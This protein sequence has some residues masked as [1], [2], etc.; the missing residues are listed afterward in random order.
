VK[1]FLSLAIA[2]APF[3]LNAQQA[4]VK[5]TI[6][7]VTGERL[8]FAS[9]VILPDSLI[10]SSDINGSY[11]IRIATGSKTL[12]VSYVGFEPL[13]F[14]KEI[15]H[16]TTINFI[17][18]PKTDQLEEV[19][20]AGDRFSNED[21][22][23]SV[24]SGTNV[25]TQK[26]V[27]QMPA[28]MG[29][30]NLLK[31]IRLLPGS[32]GG[33]EGS[34]DSFVR[35]G[36]ADQNLVLLDG[37]PIYNTGHLFGFLSV[38]NPD[39]LDKV[40]VINGG[41]PAAFGGR[42]SSVLDISS[43]SRIPEKTSIT[44]DIGLIGSRIKLEQPIIKDKASFWIAGRQ[45]Y[46]DEVAKRIFDRK[47]PYSFYDINGKVILHPSKSDQIEMSH[48]GSEDFL[49]FLNDK[50]RDGRGMFT[51]YHSTNMSQTFKWRHKTIYK[52]EKEL[53]M[54]HTYFDYRTQ[55]A[56]NKDYLVSAHSQIEDYGAKFTIEKDSVWKDALV[57]AGVEWI[58][59][60][61]S[62]RVLN[63]E[64]SI[65]DI[66]KSGSTTGKIAQ[67]FSAYVQ[68][69]WSVTKNLKINIGIRGSMAVVSSRKYIFLE[70]RLS[71]RYA[72]GKDEALKFNYSRMVQYIHRISNSAVSTPID[73]WFPV[74]DSIRPQTSHQFSLAWQRFIPS[75]KI[76]CSVEGYYKSME[77]LIAYREGT[78]FLF[79]SDFDSRLIQGKGTAYGLEFLI[80]K[81]AGKFTGWIS[82]SLSWSWRQFNELNNGAWFPARYDRRHN[83]AIVAQ[84]LI[85]KRWA[86]SMVWEYIS[87]AR[88]TP[89]V[90]QYTTLAPNGGGLDLIPIFAGINSVRL[91]DA[92]RLDL[93]IKFFNKP[94]RKFKWHWFAGV[95]NAYNRATPFGIVIKQDKSN[96]SLKYVQPG[97][98]G[99]LPFI[100]YGCKW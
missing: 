59:H 75:R 70:P 25:I 33:M 43:L 76:Y 31:A 54:F 78:N 15:H 67:E 92:H 91:S 9:V 11:S 73:V 18:T 65:A 35:G 17:M 68:Q 95:Y 20:I 97:L 81:D 51:R 77:D 49:D 50:D 82:Y 86:A 62:P 14:V 42:L 32:A 19:V 85:R 80:R 39:I 58:R 8:S 66:V 10:A 63:S 30:A 88:F 6:H 98:F 21:V 40:E 53:S 24:S 1:P 45:S 93:G 7:D 52:W 57:S 2:V 55:N 44:A 38:F 74:T 96:N 100:S 28:F 3:L 94:G 47:V 5:G 89:V 12:L 87:G 26:D 60:E 79:K 61:M 27:L 71:A 29:E 34:S 13:A 36:A 84:H 46:V 48:Y 83:G 69:E 22:V 90:G 56:Y 41:F 64:G 99:L 4:E 23:Q 16:D 72:L 37:A